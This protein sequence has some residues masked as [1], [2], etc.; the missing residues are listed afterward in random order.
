[1]GSGGF[2]YISAAGSASGTL[3]RA[4]GEQGVDSGG[5]A[6]DTTVQGGGILTALGTLVDPVISGGGVAIVD[7]LDQTSGTVTFVGSGGVL[8][9]QSTSQSQI[10][11]ETPIEGFALNDQVYLPFMSFDNDTLSVLLD[12]VTISTGSGAQYEL[13]IAGASSLSFQV[14][15][16]SNPNNQQSGTG[17]I[18]SLVGSDLGLGMTADTT[19]DNTS[20][21]C[22]AAGTRIATPSGEAEVE[23]LTSGDLVCTLSGV[24]RPVVWIGRR[25]YAGRFLAANAKVLPVRF[26][27]GSLGGGLPRRDLLVS[28]D[29]AML[30]YDLLVPARHL[31]NGTTIVQERGLD[32][33]D[34]YHV[35]LASHDVILAEG[36]PSET[37]LDDG[38]RGLFHNARE[39][40][41]RYPDAPLPGRFY[42][43]RVEDGFSLEAIRIRLGRRPSCYDQ[44]A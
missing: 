33:V 40:A 25:S 11:I 7:T 27:A 43:P 8:A 10:D 21:A 18:L 9:I 34:Y 1:V 13:N 28:P 22:Y 16:Y 2:Q 19:A 41:A 3:V 14:T 31:T 24:H 17:T 20:I 32:R 39:F 36:A 44:T 4:G 35:E 30:L 38:S 29:H 42:A 6:S 5:V 23:T 26:R 15:S 12:T 37:F